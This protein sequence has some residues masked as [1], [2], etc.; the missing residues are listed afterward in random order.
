[1][2]DEKN[3]PNEKLP[4]KITRRK[5]LS[6]SSKFF[7]GVFGSGLLGSVAIGGSLHY[8]LPKNETKK[9]SQTD[10]LVALGSVNEL[11][12]LKEPLKIDYNTSIQ[13]G[14]VE[15]K[16][17]G[18]V[19]V[20]KDTTNKLLIMSPVCTHLGCTVPFASEEQKQGKSDLAF[21]CPCHLGEY[22][23]MG[24]NIGGPPPRPLDVFEPIVKDGKIYIDIF[25][26]IKRT[27]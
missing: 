15:Q 20:T 14:W 6:D 9:E 22:D 11:N 2:S 21:L 27:T 3:T 18:F 23:P 19:Y 4:N 7:I 24:N 10:N 26:P 12:S 16:V 13:D 5:F 17:S 25:S 1:M 8:F